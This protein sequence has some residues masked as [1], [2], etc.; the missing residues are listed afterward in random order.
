MSDLVFAGIVFHL[1]LRRKHNS[2]LVVTIVFDNPINLF[3]DVLTHERY[4]FTK[5]K[6]CSVT[7]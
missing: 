7:N 3:F 2:S 4:I 1:L 6:H 5:G